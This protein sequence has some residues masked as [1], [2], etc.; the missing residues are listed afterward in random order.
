MS[1][2]WLKHANAANTQTRTCRVRTSPYCVHCV[3]GRTCRPSTCSTEAGESGSKDS[4]P[5]RIQLQRNEIERER[6]GERVCER[7]KARQRQRGSPAKGAHVRTWP[8]KSQLMFFKLGQGTFQRHQ[9]CLPADDSAS[10][11]LALLQS[12]SLT[13]AGER[14]RYLFTLGNPSASCFA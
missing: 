11:L 12:A 8:A 3:S 7:E 10:P 1:A 6:E 4:R 14:C 2:P 9:Q 13:T 5:V